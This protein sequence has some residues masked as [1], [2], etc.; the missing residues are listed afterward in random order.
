[1]KKFTHEDKL[2]LFKIFIGKRCVCGNSKNPFYWQCVVCM[3]RT[4]TSPEAISLSKTCQQH[5]N[6]A[7]D[8]IE[9]IRK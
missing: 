8:Y 6:M 2:K 4:K 9:S 7:S 3:E 1:M 5:C